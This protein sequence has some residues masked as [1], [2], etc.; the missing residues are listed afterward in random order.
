[1]LEDE[2][3]LVLGSLII[4]SRSNSNNGS[5]SDVWELKF[6]SKNVESLTRLISD[7]KLVGVVIKIE[8][9]KNLGDNIK[10]GGLFSGIL[11]LSDLVILNNIS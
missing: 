10:V 11:Q 3:L 6:Q 4:S 7:F 1:M 5:L 9:L 2:N 8:Y